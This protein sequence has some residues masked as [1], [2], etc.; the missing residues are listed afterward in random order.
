MKNGTDT[1]HTTL[2]AHLIVNMRSTAANANATEDADERGSQRNGWTYGSCV[3]AVFFPFFTE[4]ND[5][6]SA[7]R[8]NAFASKIIK[9]SL[10]RIEK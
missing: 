6:Y 5:L 10:M 7:L 2:C 1:S 4:A 8:K 3:V 9:L